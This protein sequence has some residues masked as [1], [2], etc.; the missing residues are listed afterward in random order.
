MARR[1]WTSPAYV[2]RLLGG[3]ANMTLKTLVQVAVA[4]G[5]GIDVFVPSSVREQRGHAAQAHP[6]KGDKEWGTG[7]RGVWREA[8]QSAPR[9][10]R[11]GR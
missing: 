10:A 3:T 9:V 11:G 2:T 5:K 4:L 7:R 8:A 1:L 6:P